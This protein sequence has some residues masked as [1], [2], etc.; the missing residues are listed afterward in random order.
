MSAVNELL[1]YARRLLTENELDLLIQHDAP[2][3]GP[4]GLR[5]YLAERSFEAFCKLYFGE[6][7]TLDIPPI[8]QRIIADCQDIIDR[9]TQ[10]KHGIKLARAIPR[11]HAKTTFYAR[12]LPLHGL[13]FNW[14]PLTVLL[15]NNQTAAERLL[16]NIKTA[17]ESNTAI[18]EDFPNVAGDV[19]G[20]ERLETKATTEQGSLAQQGAAIVAF[21]IGSG[22][23]RG[24]STPQRPKLI[25]GDDLDDD[26]SVRSTVQLESNKAWFDSAVMQLGDNVGFTTSVVVVGTLIRKTSLLKYILDSPDFD[27]IIE[28]GVKRFSDNMLWREWEQRYKALAV[29]GQQPKDAESD[30][31]Y[32]QHKAALLEGTEVLWNRPDAYYAMMVYKLARGEKAFQ[33][34][35]QNQPQDSGSRFGAL[36]FTPLPDDLNE[37]QLLGALDPTI[38]GGKTND[39]AAWVEVLFHYRTKQIIVSYCDAKQRSYADT[40]TDVVGRVTRSTKRYD[41]LF[42]ESNNAGAIIADD[43]EAKLRA[44]HYLINRVT[45]SIPKH[46]RIDVLSQYIQSGQLTFAPAISPLLIEEIESF[47]NGGHDD[48]LDSLSTIILHLRNTRQLDIVA[49]PDSRA[50]GYSTSLVA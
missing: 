26:A 42:V 11:S 48:A 32:Q 27:S 5:R 29:E 24:I 16:K 45:N 10:G 23:I 8:H 46:E 37:W 1:H 30:T 39:Y 33:S 7:F 20:Q 36:T 28:Q 25:I 50:L 35:I 40:I 3:Y 31:F 21:G 4:G 19:W 12:L 41:G 22:S 38:K 18:I 44:N 6:E 2:L 15:G 9:A 17:I 47:P 49:L 43:I 14:S 34:E 13:L